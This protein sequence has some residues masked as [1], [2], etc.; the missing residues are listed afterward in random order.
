MSNYILKEKTLLHT[1]QIAAI[2]PIMEYYEWEPK[3]SFTV[4]FSGGYIM[5]LMATKE[6]KQGCIGYTFEELEREYEYLVKAIS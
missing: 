3:K 6:V 4:T 2:S 5:T 1:K